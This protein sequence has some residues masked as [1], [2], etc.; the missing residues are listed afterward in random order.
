[1]S[2][3]FNPFDPSASH[4]MNASLGIGAGVNPQGDVS[5]VSAQVSTGTTYER[6]KTLATL[7]NG[8]INITDKENS[9]DL[10]RLNTDTTQVDKSLFQTNTGTSASGTLD[11]RLLTAEGRAQI[12]EDYEK[13]KRLGEAAYETATMDSVSIIADQADGQTSFVERLNDKEALAQ[14][15]KIIEKRGQATF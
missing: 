8:N 9:D 4:G 2:V 12:K 3:I 1:M 13:T 6:T 15:S 11:T 5:S 10:A 7:G 14:A